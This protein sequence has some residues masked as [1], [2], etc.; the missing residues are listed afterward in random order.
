MEEQKEIKCP[1][2]QNKFGFTFGICCNCGYNHI[3]NRFEYIEVPVDILITL[4]KKETDIL[5]L[6]ER[7][8]NNKKRKE[9]E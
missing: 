3:S 4:L 5:Y 9:D 7:H 2:C 1:V 8:Y 6:V